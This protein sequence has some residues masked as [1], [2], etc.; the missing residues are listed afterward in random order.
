[1]TVKTDLKITT[2]HVLIA[3]AGIG[4]A[5]VSYRSYQGVKVAAEKAKE[6]AG[7]VG[8][9]INPADENNLINR[10]VNALGAKITGDEHWTLGGAIYDL[11]HDPV[12]VNTK[13]VNQ[14]H[15][16]VKEIENEAIN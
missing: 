3:A 4:I 13:A 9:A 1:M 16:D 8:T 14:D 10:G 15:K 6:V 5:Y 12:P 7:N 2:N 11:L